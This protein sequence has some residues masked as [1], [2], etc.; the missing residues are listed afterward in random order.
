MSAPG[1]DRGSVRDA[2]IALALGIAAACL[3]LPMLLL[4]AGGCD[5]WHVLQIGV[6]LRAGDLL[7]TDTNHIAGPGAFYGAAGLFTLF[8][9]SFAVARTAMLG[10]FSL[11]VAC[12]YL[13]SRRLVGPVAATIAALLLIAFRLWTFP[14]FTIFHYATTALIIVTAGFWVLR[15]HESPQRW[16]VIAAGLIGGVAFIT[17][18][19]SGALGG[20]GI[21]L[22]LLAGFAIRR[23]AGGEREKVGQTATLF[24]VAAGTPFLLA[25]L[26]FLAH[27]GLGPYLWQTIYDPIFLN[28]LMGSG[29]GPA[30][31]D[32]VDIPALF[33]LASQD[34]DLR[35]LLFSWMPGL[36]WDLHWRDVLNST[37][38]R[39]TNLLD[40]FLKI[41]Y[42]LPTLFL[43]G[44]AFSLVRSWRRLRH[45]AAAADIRALAARAA[46]LAFTG[47]MWMAFSK[48]RDWIHFSIL[49]VPFLP[50]F[51]R[52][53]SALLA[54][55]PRGARP[56]VAIPAAAA[57]LLFVFASAHLE[58]GAIATF[59]TPVTGK[60]GTV[61]VRAEDAIAFQ[62]LIDHLATTPDD[63][64][65][66]VVPCLPVL[67]FL[68]DRPTASR[69]IWLWPRDAYA[70]R[71]EQIMAAL[72][73]EPDTSL[74]YVLMHTPF[75]P[76][77]Q[78]VIPELF[79]YVAENYFLDEVI[80]APD[81]LVCG[82]AARRSGTEAVAHLRL[83]ASLDN[84]HARLAS[85]AEVPVAE[86]VGL[87][88][89]PLTRGVVYLKPGENAPNTLS[90][91]LRV[92]EG[93]R[94]LASAG[95]HPDLWQSLGAFPLRLGIE[96]RS[97]RGTETLLRTEKD[98]FGRPDDR[99]WTPV[100]AD[101]AAWAGEE[102]EI[103]FSTEA[104][105][106]KPGQREMA[107]FAEARIVTAQP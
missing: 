49:L 60:R 66:L 100:D 93:A 7:Y 89:W 35:H 65:V 69:F 71:D 73:A 43:L 13:L 99:L 54:R 20:A 64:K 56:L 94:L 3:H 78:V 12:T 8:G 55:L 33:P 28:Q 11:L 51:A 97:S 101:L 50:I 42:R 14:H 26:Y 30:A 95:V 86:L 34:A 76:R 53:L 84:A 15:A 21:F 9:E 107:G 77:P 37:L 98:V 57:G 58:R 105:G 63:Q 75:A 90:W 24:L 29:G 40:V 92:P 103:I 83:D 47:G 1:N 39:D 82:I 22:A 5:E 38:Y 18:Q 91:R 10:L 45:G 27:G 102:V 48:P 62:G 23:R 61:W 17:K 80:G 88:N 46:Q 4:V 96:L 36:L 104:L 70:D 32:Y 106:W 31:A 72:E 81:R 25:C 74:V 79:D 2:W 67:S 19:D 6:N 59:D 41:L 44:E 68:A 85:G 87:E 52:Q 16:R